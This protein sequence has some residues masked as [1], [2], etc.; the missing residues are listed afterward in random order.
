V[1]FI[2]QNMSGENGF[3]WRN[4]RSPGLRLVVSLVEQLQGTVELNL[5]AGTEFKI[6]VE[7]KE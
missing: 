6:I 3:G 7:E 1:Y 4:A 5:S 2:I